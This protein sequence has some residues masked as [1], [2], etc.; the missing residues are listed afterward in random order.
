MPSRGKGRRREG[1]QGP[2]LEDLTLT[3]RGQGISVS[4]KTHSDQAIS[5]KCCGHA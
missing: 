4:F 3:H 1:V 5:P 2:N